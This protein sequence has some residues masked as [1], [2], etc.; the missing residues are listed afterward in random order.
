MTNH[1]FN[2]DLRSDMY[3]SNAVFNHILHVPTLNIGQHVPEAFEEFIESMCDTREGNQFIEQWPRFKPMVDY[4]R[5]H[6]DSGMES[7]FAQEIANHVN[8]F[9]FLI[10]IE[11]AVPKNFK[12]N[13]EGKPVS[14][15]ITGWR[16]GEWIF[17]SDMKQ[18]AQLAIQKSAALNEEVIQKE[19]TAKEQL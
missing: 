13:E 16:R 18:A 17:A 1:S 4:M 3:E 9:E 5:A 11:L 10:H 2:Y 19:K 14:W 15:N 8:D 6:A 12:F 7:E